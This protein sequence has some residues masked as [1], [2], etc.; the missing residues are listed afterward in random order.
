MCVSEF[1]QLVLLFSLVCDSCLTTVTVDAWKVES[2]IESISANSF[3]IV[4]R[5]IAR[6]RAIETGIS[7]DC[8]NILQL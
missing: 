1:T 7:L 2:T 4:S 3:L 6:P 5:I 8:R